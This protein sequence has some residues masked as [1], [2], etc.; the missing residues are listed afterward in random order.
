MCA[1]LV[2]T[3]ASL[4]VDHQP[5]ELTAFCAAGLIGPFSEIGQIF[6]NSTGINIVFNFDGVQVLRTQV[7][8][9]AYADLFVS[10]SA[11][12]LN[13]LKAEDIIN[14]S[15]ISVIAKN[16]VA[17]IV[18]KDN[19]GKIENL[20]DLAKPDIK[21]I[22]GAKDVPIGDYALQVLDNLEKDPTYGSEY[23]NK[24]LSNIV[25]EETNVNYILSKVGLGEVDA[26]FA[27][28]SK[29]T[30]D[31]EKKITRIMIPDRYNVIAEY[32]IGILKQSEYPKQAED[33][34]NLLKS[35]K[36][37]AI[38]EKYGFKSAL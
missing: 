2:F 26:G 32:N 37:I 14:N 9:G 8:N 34:I 35:D 17:L 3:P 11:K 4:C 15:S 18:P 27:W 22:I 6:K 36:G 28:Q 7:E 25:S 19:P 21:I 33:F 1:I 23:K 38:L 31:M 16:R 24:V 13:A 29:S 12:H 10:S 30:E 5:K 20:S